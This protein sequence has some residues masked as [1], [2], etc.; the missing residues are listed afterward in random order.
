MGLVVDG[1]Y[2]V[3]GLIERVAPLRGE[4]C[5]FVRDRYSDATTSVGDIFGALACVG[6]YF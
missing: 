6:G 3:G 1:A 4:F 5:V 2:D